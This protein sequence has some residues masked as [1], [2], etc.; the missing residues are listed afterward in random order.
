MYCARE[1]PSSEVSVPCAHVLASMRAPSARSVPTKRG[2]LVAMQSQSTMRLGPRRAQR[3]GRT[4][5]SRCD[6]PPCSRRRAGVERAFVALDDEAVGQL[7]ARDAE[8]AQH[9]APSSR[10]GRSPS[11]AA[12]RRR[13]WSSS[14]SRAPRARTRSGSRRSR[15]ARAR[16]RPSMRAQ[17]RAATRV[18]SAIGS[19]PA[20]LAARSR[21]RAPMSRAISRMPV[22]VGFMPTPRTV[23]REP[24]TICAATSRNAAAERSPGISMSNAGILP[25]H[26]AGSSSTIVPTRAERH[27][28]RVQHPLGVIARER[29]LLEVRRAVGVEAREQERAL[30]LRARDRALVLERAE[31]LA[32]RERAD[33]QRRRISP[34][35]VGCGA[36]SMIAPRARSGPAT[37]IIGRRVSDASP[38]SVDANGCAAR[39]PGEEAHRRAGVAA[40]ERVLRRAGGPKSPTPSTRELAGRRRR[41]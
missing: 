14:R 28:E 24:A 38:T 7:F 21:C 27:A 25:S 2:K 36:P 3:R 17:R 23:T 12:P 5:S 29:R 41:R 18:I 1:P 13:G 31:R 26:P 30:H 20:R 16:R 19:P 15:A 39:T 35:F 34:A 10:C 32:V 4:P 37:R 9:A 40:V 22:R 11:R 6:G 8:R 33:A